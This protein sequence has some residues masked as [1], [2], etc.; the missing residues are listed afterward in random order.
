MPNLISTMHLTKKKPPFPLL[1]VPKVKTSKHPRKASFGRQGLRSAE[2]QINTRC[3]Q[4]RQFRQ[5]FLSS[6]NNSLLGSS[7]RFNLMP[8]EEDI[9]TSESQIPCCG[10]RWVNRAHDD[11]STES[12]TWLEGDLIKHIQHMDGK[13]AG[14]T[15]NAKRSHNSSS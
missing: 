13:N 12:T 7:V 1:S 5:I 4:S 3:S 15:R 11:P 2:A 8:W 9:A 14:A 10:S 6:V